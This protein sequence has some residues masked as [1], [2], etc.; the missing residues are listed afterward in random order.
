MAL[1]RSSC[2]SVG[3]SWKRCRGREERI[4]TRVAFKDPAMGPWLHQSTRRFTSTCGAETRDELDF[5]SYQ[6]TDYIHRRH[7][8]SIY[9][10]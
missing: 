5:I 1:E 4:R 9:P 6:T 10:P 2:S 7:K 3:Q 8:E